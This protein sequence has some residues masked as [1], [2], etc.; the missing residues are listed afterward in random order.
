MINGRRV[1]DACIFFNEV[2]M[3]DLRMHILD[4]VVDYFVVVE[5]LESIG[6]NSRKSKPLCFEANKFLH[7]TVFLILPSLEPQLRDLSTGWQQNQYM[8]DRMQRE[9]YQRDRMMA[10]A[11]SIMKSETD[12]LL[13]SDVDEIPRPEIV[14]AFGSL[15][16][17][18][19]LALD[20]YYYNVNWRAEKWFEGTTIGTIDEYNLKGGI[21]KVRWSPSTKVIDNAGWHFSYFGGVERIRDKIKHFSHSSDDMCQDVIVRKDDEIA[22]DIRDGRDLYR[23]EDQPLEHRSST[24][25][26]LPQYFLQHKDKYTQFT[27]EGMTNLRESLI[28]Q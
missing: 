18:H 17:I 20:F 8:S 22:Q 2:D 7:K 1:I 5:S 27:E 25:P 13:A 10:G 3:L 15:S 14:E 24:D 6:I 9:K 19:R 28:F 11:F 16:G 26:S 21:G 12:L 23:R 4:P